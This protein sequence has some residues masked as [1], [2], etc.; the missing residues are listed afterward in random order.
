M[1]ELDQ[2]VL[3]KWLFASIKEHLYLTKGYL[4]NPEGQVEIEYTLIGSYI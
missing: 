4:V 3:Q 1:K 2:I